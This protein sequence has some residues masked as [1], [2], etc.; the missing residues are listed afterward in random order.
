MF[1]FL[2]SSQSKKQAS[3]DFQQRLQACFDPSY[4]VEAYPHVAQAGMD[5]WRHFILHGC[6]E[7]FWP[8]E[9]EAL[10][11]EKRLWIE[12]KQEQAEQDLLKLLERNDVVESTAA[13]WFLG[14]WYASRQQWEEVVKI[15]AVHSQS[16]HCLP[17]HFTPKLLWL[18]ALR[19]TNPKQGLTYLKQLLQQ[20]GHRVD[21]AF[22]GMNFVDFNAE[23]ESWKG[24]NHHYAMR[25][26]QLIR[27]F[28]IS[29]YRFDG[30]EGY[31]N[32]SPVISRNIALT[33]DTVS[34]IVPTYNAEVTIATALR[35]LTQ[36]SWPHLEILVVDDASTDATVAVVKQWQ[37][38][39]ARIRLLEQPI[40]QGAYKTR[41]IGLQHSIGQYITV[42]DSDDWSHPQ[43]IALQVQPLL[44]KTAC[45]ATVSHWIRV[46]DDLIFGSWSAPEGWDS[47]IHRNVSSL[48]MRREVFEQLGYWDSVVCS[49]DTEY[50]YRIL[51]AYGKESIQEVQ[52]GIPLAFG[53]V[54]ENSLTQRSETHIFSIF[55]GLRHDYRKA[56][57]NWHRE[58]N[59]IQALYME[60]LPDQRPF[61]VSR[62]MISKSPMS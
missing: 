48:L 58:C 62:K 39:D 5:P 18:E 6:A 17:G 31:E 54:R 37:K 53:R 50:Y 23:K 1:S 15:M 38:K 56:Y 16:S 2:S 44:Q 26:L 21:L 42:H 19:Q 3:C 61:Q 59:T 55:S 32:P 51:T 20:H 28:G 14:R 27:P 46:S 24:I 43:K 49:A 45:K 9:I 47:T 41:N 4:Y 22:M 30:L 7:G 34:V 40:N 25:G 13:A 29:S 10:Q 52:T 12:T 57:E 36:Q 8:A 33:K 11:V 35:G 60:R